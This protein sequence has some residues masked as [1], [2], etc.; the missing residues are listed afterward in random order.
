MQCN[1]MH[2]LVCVPFSTYLTLGRS[3]LD[4]QAFLRQDIMSDN[5]LLYFTR[6]VTYLDNYVYNTVMQ[7]LSLIYCSSLSKVDISLY[8]TFLEIFF[9]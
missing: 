2:K 5:A 3:V 4:A 9:S 7:I 6:K 1:A 8:E